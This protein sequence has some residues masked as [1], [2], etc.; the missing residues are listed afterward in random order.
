MVS[1]DNIN[2]KFA[3]ADTQRV[4]TGPTD[5][6]KGVNEDDYKIE[7]ATDVKLFDK[8]EVTQ[9]EFVPSTSGSSLCILVQDTVSI[10]DSDMQEIL[11]LDSQVVQLK[12]FS[13]DN[14][15]VLSLNGTLST[16][17]IMTKQNKE[18]ESEVI[19]FDIILESSELILI[20]KDNTVVKINLLTSIS[21]ALKAPELESGFNF[22]YIAW[23]G[24]SKYISISANE[25]L[26]A[27]L[28]LTDITT[29]TTKHLQD[30]FPPLSTDDRPLYF[31]HTILP[32]WSLHYPQIV[33]ISSSLSSELITI[34]SK[35]LIEH[36]NDTDRAQLPLD[37]DTY[38][39]SLPLGLCVDLSSQ[40]DVTLDIST[41][42]EDDSILPLPRLIVWTH[43]GKLCSWFVFEVED[44]KKGNL[45]PLEDLVESLKSSI[46]QIP[47]NASDAT[48]VTKSSTAPTTASPFAS[49]GSKSDDKTSL[50]QNTFGHTGSLF[51]Q[52]SFESSKPLFGQSTFG[53]SDTTKSPFASLGSNN[54][55]NDNK[56][57]F[58]SSSFGSTKTS[59][60]S[61]FASLGSKANDKPLFGSSSFGSTQPSNNSPFASLGSK[62]DEKPLFGSSTFGSTSFGSSKAGN[63]SPFASLGA[64]SEEKPLFGSS[65]FGSSHTSSLFGQSSFGATKPPTGSPFASLTSKDND[66]PLF[67]LSTFGSSNSTTNSPFATLGSNKTSESPFAS[68]SST[69]KPAGASG[70]SQESSFFGKPSQT[71][72]SPFAHLGS[73]FGSSK[74]D[75]KKSL[76]PFANLGTSFGSTLQES[77]KINS[78]SSDDESD[79]NTESDSAV[80]SEQEDKP[81]PV[82]KASIKPD[83]NPLGPTTF[84]ESSSFGGPTSFGSGASKFGS[85]GFGSSGFGSL[86]ANASE[87]ATLP[88]FGSIGENKSLFGSFSKTSSPF[89]DFSKQKSP[90]ESLKSTSLGFL[91][92]A[93]EDSK[94]EIDQ[95]EEVPEEE[96]KDHDSSMESFV[97]VEKSVI[98]DEGPESKDT[99]EILKTPVSEEELKDKPVEE[100]NS[101]ELEE[102]RE[103]DNELGE[104]EEAP[105][106][107]VDELELEEEV[108][109]LSD[110]STAPEEIQSSEE[111]DTNGAEEQVE[112][113]QVEDDATEQKLVEQ[114]PAEQQPVEEQTAQPEETS[115]NTEEVS[116]LVS[117][118]NKMKGFKLEDINALSSEEK[119]LTIAELLKAMSLGD[120][121]ISALLSK[122]DDEENKEE[123]EE[124]Q[125]EQEE[126][127]EEI[128]ESE[129]EDELH[130]RRTHQPKPFPEFIKI[131]NI[132]F[133]QHSGSLIETKIYQLYY[134]VESHMEVMEK[135]LKSLSEFVHDQE[136][137]H[138][139]PST[140]SIEYP[141]LWRLSESDVVSKWVSEKI[142]QVSQ[143]KDQNGKLESD[144][145]VLFEKVESNDEKLIE[146]SNIL[147]AFKSFQSNLKYLKDKK[148]SFINRSLRS[149]LSKKFSSYEA[150]VKSL[151][152]KL[153]I[154]KVILKVV[155]EGG[156]SDIW[157]QLLGQLHTL[158]K[159]HYSSLKKLEQ[160]LKIV[161]E[162]ERVSTSDAIE[163][164]FEIGSSSLQLVPLLINELQ[165][166]QVSR[167]KIGELLRSRKI[168]VT[169]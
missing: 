159:S 14:V 142:P 107:E 70:A 20:K 58:G 124:E 76:S 134:S 50:G 25:E 125:E 18:I 114:E 31:Y 113:D 144:L 169:K 99:L 154:F 4:F 111:E 33:I 89:G 84:G 82:P 150:T 152:A 30:I 35:G 132:Q 66:K 138:F 69:T 22:K 129:D 140:L 147:N 52:S 39:D 100:S 28:Y 92:E 108:E 23:V 60:D 44:I 81:P 64:K 63:E 139:E 155:N 36:L 56:P 38:I 57:L 123:Q 83:T 6:L 80:N 87:K 2:R 77:S 53:S 73:S 74:D 120:D 109:N 168:S 115:K 101:S 105:S 98:P 5:A 96:T 21:E 131:S 75:E 127:P 94:E 166:S 43:D 117:L 55:N 128:Q 7:N 27:T 26:D 42:I 162:I 103:E 48:E 65:A 59:S 54:D 37:D 61:P 141:S 88:T 130:A 34:T 19:S 153:L 137:S 10:L 104:Q 72:D 3:F 102:Q 119:N 149:E 143:I 51:G 47:L 45:S 161:S 118:I 13:Y 160:E 12:Y 116:P 68:L 29:N 16:L 97:E 9:V 46:K 17:N 71:S 148:L 110:E 41:K 167:F 15:A 122:A 91:N 67:G 151:E 90:F 157:D 1:W 135:N 8:S 106:V 121:S 40:E 146:I 62:T 11:K 164:D 156:N 145:E 165:N 93:K 136:S 79:M 112:D 133:P 126:E 86:T 163:D 158:M 49:L 32:K 78:P 85:S 95:A 24:E